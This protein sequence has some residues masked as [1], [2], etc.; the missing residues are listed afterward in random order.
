[1]WRF[2]VRLILRNRNTI[3]ISTLLITIFMGYM[4]RNV[5][6][7]YEM[8]QMLPD[9]D[10][11]WIDYMQFREKFGQD[12]AVMFV[13]L[14]TEDLFE[15]EHFQAWYDLTHQ[16]REQEGIEEVLS[17]ARLYNLSRN[18]S[19]KRFDFLPIVS[20]RPETQVEVDSIHQVINSLP[21]YDGLLQNR[22]TGVSLMMITLDKQMLNT[23]ARVGLIYSIKDQLDEFAQEHNIKVHY[24]GLPYIRT[25]TTKM[26]EDELR[27]FVLLALVV[28]ALILMFFFRSFKATIFPIIIVI[29]SVVWA[30]G[31][32]GLFGFKI[33]LLTGI[34]PPLIIVIGV[35]NCIFLLNKYHDEYREHQNKV[36]ALARVILRIGN[37]N[38]LTN[39][40]TAAG[41]AAFTITGNKMLVEF[42]IVASLNILAVYLLSLF[43]IPTF[44]SYLPPP[45]LRHI[46]HLNGGFVNRILD[47]ISW[48]VQNRRR[49]IYAFTLVALVAAG[50]GISRLTTTGKVVDEIPQNHQL[51]RDLMFLEKHFK[52]VMPLE[53]TI[54]TKKPKGAMKQS[55]LKRVDKLQNMLQ[56]YPQLS[57]PLSVVEVVKFGKQAFFRGKESFYNVP[58]RDELNFI[59]SY[60]P[61]DMQTGSKSLL[62]NFVDTTY[63]TIRVSVQMANIGTKEIQALTDEIRPRIDSIFPPK[64]YDVV[65]TGTSVTF[66]TGTNYLAKNLFQSL[67]LA[68]VVI[69]ILMAFLFTSFRMVLISLVPNL[70]PQIM[71][72]ALMGYLDIPI[73]PSTILIFSIAL[74]I[75]VD[76][77]IHFLSRYRLQLQWNNWE[78]QKSVIMALRE[79]GYSMI[80]SSVVLFFGFAIFVLSSFGGTESLGYLVSFTLFVALFSNMFL[81][82]SILL[83]ADKYLTNKNFEKPY[84][85]IFDGN[86][87]SEDVEVEEK[88]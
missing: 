21:F 8:V 76:N 55:V 22:E 69:T 73:K 87:L 25:I 63:Q 61:N 18:D 1:M 26:A 65:I 43:L 86:E 83:S 84:L 7:S 66:L 33:T 27:L 49:L 53:I 24:S 58:S 77:A 10:S 85:E 28:A 9:N 46:Q 16:L 42:G 40:T 72:A 3:L 52:G 37:A 64:N 51:Y 62:D 30:V 45:K 12:G 15:L 38:F 5:K 23:K 47:K 31:T 60:I 88:K 54:D 19:L 11:T 81:L 82:P 48:T 35:E 17:L 20:Q 34:I 36:K 59:A 44:F 78:I 2:L 4:A 80:Y 74:G 29:I 14:E 70:I 13:G 6:L 79:T 71:T 56:Q 68:I 32:I 75:S 50:F 67:I 41:F 39:A 57:K